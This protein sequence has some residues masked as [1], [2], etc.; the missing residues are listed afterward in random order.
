MFTFETAD[1][2][3]VRRCRMAQFSGRPATVTAK[4]T[5]V[6]GLVH[7]VHAIEASSPPRWTIALIPITPKPQM[8]RRPPRTPRASL[9]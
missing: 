2:K 6:T 7:A 1:S 5:T 4:G 3:D 8:P 9:P